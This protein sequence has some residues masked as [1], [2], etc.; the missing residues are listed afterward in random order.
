[1]NDNDNDARI[2]I[3]CSICHEPMVG[4]IKKLSCN[5]EFHKACI[6]QWLKLRNNCPLC[7]FIVKN[8]DVF[9]NYKQNTPI[10][11]IECTFIFVT[12]GLTIS[13]LCTILAILVIAIIEIM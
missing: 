12:T 6:T 9:N 1:M 7:R 11:R 4:D 13:I 8:P 5:H 2:N 3:I 10:N